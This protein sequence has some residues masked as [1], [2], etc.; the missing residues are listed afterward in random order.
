MELLKSARRRSL[1]SETLYIGLNILLAAMTLGIVLAVAVPW[2]ALGLVMLSKWRIFAV[3]SRYWMANIR[4][5]MIDIIVGFSVVVYLY[6]ATGS[7]VTQ[8]V[9][10]IMYAIWL[11]FIKPR[12][13]RR[14]VA[15]QA[16]IGLTFGIG[17]IIEL[18]PNAPSALVVLGT[19]MV[20]YSAARHVMSAQKEAH[21]NFFSL[22]WGFV[23]A[24]IA[25][26]SYHWTI[27]YK[28]M[29]V[30]QLAQATII[31]VLLSFLAERTYMS[32]HKNGSIRL[33][34]VILPALMSIS[35]I[36]LLLVFFGGGAETV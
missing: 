29:G 27:G 21:I 20:G 2:P 11:L 16:L 33:N 23:V 5:N 26:L 15:L 7:L 14:Y 13:K 19:W 28:V 17:A 35:I 30:L 12:S 34:D 8:I 9:L 18:S 22:V 10:T 4:A 3:R 31:I 1:W 6:A 25:W 32:Y 36:A 24:E